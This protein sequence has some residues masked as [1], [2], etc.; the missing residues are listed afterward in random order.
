M[1]KS[2]KTKIILFLSIISL[3]FVAVIFLMGYLETKNITRTL[4]LQKHEKNILLDKSITSLSNN[5]KMFSYDYSV[6][7][8]VVKFIEN[9]DLNWAENNLKTGVETYNVDY[10][11][12][13]DLNYNLVYSFANKD[14]FNPFEPTFFKN[15]IKN[16]N[17]FNHFFIK[18]NDIFIEIMTAPIQPSNDTKRIT[19][20]KG[21]F[22]SGLVWNEEYIKNLE[23]FNSSKIE[24]IS[25]DNKKEF[26]FDKTIIVSNKILYSYESKP[27]AKIYSIT[28][29]ALITKLLDFI[30]YKMFVFFI[31]ALLIV[32][33][34]V[35]FLNMFLNKPINIISN[36]LK[37]GNL[38]ELAKI[39]RQNNEFSNIAHLIIEF[40][41]QKKQ[42]EQTKNDLEIANKIRDEF[43]TN[44]S[45]EIRTPINAIIGF[46]ELLKDSIT[47]K[48]YKDYLNGINLSSNN[49]LLLVDD[50]INL[51]KLNMNMI[52][53]SMDIIDISNLC[54]KIGQFFYFK[55]KDKKLNFIIELEQNLPNKIYMNERY[56]RQILINLLSNGFKFTQNGFVK[57]TINHNTKDNNLIDLILI[58]EDS[59]MGITE[60]TKSNI[61]KIFYQKDSGNKK[62]YDGLGLGLPIV[63]KLLDYLN[64]E[65]EIESEINKG[66][67]FKIIL[68]NIV[69]QKEETV[70]KNTTN[71]ISDRQNNEDS[72]IEYISKEHYEILKT[73]YKSKIDEV[74]SKMIIDEISLF[75][76][77]LKDFA[78]T[79]NI[80]SIKKYS[81]RMIDASNSFNID[82][83]NE[84]LL[85]FDNILKQIEIKKYLN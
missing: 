3:I 51:T 77:N 58:I 10:L 45:H 56:L 5:L 14:N 83:I 35:I 32:I 75:A 34:I 24:I 1:F 62:K 48:K 74:K 67:I 82:E 19:F 37:T 52:D 50:M 71:I 11:W 39:E 2:I 25:F 30:S 78:V 4:N 21:Y 13:F 84:L 46:S 7:D 36:T 65:I 20:P 61:F 26:N 85:N 17:Y 31:F 59:G 73:V 27:I 38:G 49:L 57:L 41:N 29:S 76:E 42:L 44:I 79:N 69:V 72:E 47:I 23:V 9:K 33:L 12:I 55:I 53:K 6:C 80:K 18:H 15:F 28:K 16:N 66:S 64:G 68:K 70:I 60:E 63:K 40:F 43:I 22:I 8:E 54:D 81:E